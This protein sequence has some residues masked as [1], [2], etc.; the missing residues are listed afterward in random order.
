MS[1]RHRRGFFK[2][3]F[4]WESPWGKIYA[5][6]H[7]VQA[8]ES[9]VIGGVI[10]SAVL[11]CFRAFRVQVSCNLLILFRIPVLQCK[12]TGHLYCFSKASSLT[13]V[14]RVAVE[15]VEFLRGPCK[16]FEL[17]ATLRQPVLINFCVLLLDSYIKLE[18]LLVAP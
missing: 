7:D 17:S 16:K 2:L 3:P 13:L 4:I 5:A 1:S 10:N 9:H 6:L 14:T 18:I 15:N 12:E 11:Q 8:L